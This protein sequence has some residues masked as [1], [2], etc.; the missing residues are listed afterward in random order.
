[1][2]KSPSTIR[3][4][5]VG[6]GFIGPHHV[7]AMRRLGF[8]QV[9]AVCSKRPGVTRQKA[10][11]LLIP[12]VYDSWDQL[13]ADPEIDVVDIVTPTNLHY[14][15]AM[16]A[17]K[18][19]KHVIVDKPLAL[20]AAQ[21][22]EMALAA[23][24]AGVV[25]AVT[26]N[27]RYNPV[28]QQARVMIGRGDAGEIHLIHGHYLQEWLLYDTDYSWRLDPE[29]AG[30]AAM[31]ADA[32]SHWFDLVEHVTGLRIRSVL[33]ELRTML[34]HRRRPL[35]SHENLADVVEVEIEDYEVR[36]PDLGSALLRFDN[37]ASGSFLTT[38]MCAGHKN[39]LRFEIHGSKAS[40]AWVQEEPNRLWIGK[41]G[42]P[43]RVIIKDPD[44]LDPSVRHYA[45]LPGGHNEAWP[46]AFK[47]TMAN[48]FEFIAS[49]QDPRSADGIQFPTFESGRRVAAIAEAL[50]ASTACGGVW[51][52]VVP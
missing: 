41:R 37:G 28:V 17:I 10:G 35:G 38:S 27:Y 22:Q 5:I 2:S 32:G 45:A 29:I 24:E 13:I 15:V 14:A 39:D 34:K 33:S 51:T 19:G 18:R 40:M 48:I 44:L 36:V 25:N 9:V 12:K 30:E 21:A 50:L 3:A 16:A 46:D 1:V 4:G 26:F 11:R 47:N 31:V 23:S 49:G 42:E 7:E 43:D 20:S 6:F 52:E 8:V